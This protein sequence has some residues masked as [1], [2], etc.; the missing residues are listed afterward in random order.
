MA[1]TAASR[2]ALAYPSPR[3]ATALPITTTSARPCE[4]A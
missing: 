4:T 3:P 1:A 2:L